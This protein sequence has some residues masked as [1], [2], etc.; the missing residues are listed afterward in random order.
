MWA[1]KLSSRTGTDRQMDWPARIAGHDLG[2]RRRA[3]AVL[4]ELRVEISEACTRLADE[5]GQ[6]PLD[7]HD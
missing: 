6:P 1:R 4:R 5:Q 7:E 2:V 3:E